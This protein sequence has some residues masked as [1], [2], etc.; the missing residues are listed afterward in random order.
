MLRAVVPTFPAQPDAVQVIA[1]TSAG[2]EIRAIEPYGLRTELMGPR[3]SVQSL[4]RERS[5]GHVTEIPE[6]G[7]MNR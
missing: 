7:K 4:F 1:K 6:M 3:A 5:I 2:I